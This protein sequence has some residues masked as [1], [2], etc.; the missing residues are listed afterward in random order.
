MFV[1][2]QVADERA[3]PLGE[4]VDLGQL[5]Q[6][7]GVPALLLHGLGLGHPLDEP[8]ANGADFFGVMRAALL[9]DYGGAL[10]LALREQRP[11]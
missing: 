10:M 5:S 11:L 1:G 3:F 9:G 2:D 7:D 4:V 8:V 6:R